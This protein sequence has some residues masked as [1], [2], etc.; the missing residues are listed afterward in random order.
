MVLSN[1]ERQK[2]FR[3]RR[4]GLAASADLKPYMRWYTEPGTSKHAMLTLAF[5]LALARDG[6]VSESADDDGLRL[7][8][9]AN[10]ARL[11]EEAQKAL[12][13]LRHY[14][15]PPLGDDDDFFNTGEGTVDVRVT[16]APLIARK[17]KAKR[18]KRKTGARK[19]AK[20]KR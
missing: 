12:W 7:Q 2:Q 11:P 16:I 19:P 5:L 15:C 3:E 10:R 6:S 14:V 4:R 17:L 20:R 8:I 13:T 1:A 18:A 9:H